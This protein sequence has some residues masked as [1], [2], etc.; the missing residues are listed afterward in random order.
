MMNIGLAISGNLT[1]FSRFY[2][3]DEAKKLL[4]TAKFNFDVHNLVSF[5]NNGEKLYAIFFSKD[6]VAVSLITNILDSFRRPGNLVVTILIPRGFKIV[7][8]L[9]LTRANAL[10]HL[11]NEINDKFYERN[12][13]NGMVNQNPA[14]LMQ[15]YYTEILSKFKLEPDN[16]Q[17]NINGL[18]DITAP[19]KRTGYVSAFENSIPSYLSSLFRKSYEGYHHIF[20]ASNAPQ[21]IDEPAEEIVTYRVKIENKDKI[22]PGEIKI[23][24][25]IPFITKSLGDNDIPS[26][27]FTY[28]Q[29]I[30]G[31]AVPYIT[32]VRT[33]GETIVLNYNFPKEEKTIYFKFY[34]GANEVPLHVIRPLIV[35]SNGS[36]YPLSTDSW[37]FRG[38]EIY[39]LK[40]IKSG[41]TEYTIEPNSSHLDLQ[42]L[43][44][45]ASH[46]VYVGKG[47]IWNFN[48]IDTRT[49]RP[50]TIHPVDIVLENRVTGEYR[51]FPRVTGAVTERMS[52]KESDWVMKITSDY[53]EPITSTPNG[54]GYSFKRKQQPLPH[55][56]G[57]SQRTDVQRGGTQTRTQGHSSS[58]QNLKLSGGANDTA[59]EQARIEAEKKK[60]YIQIGIYA[61]VAIICCIGGWWGYTKLNPSKPD[62][63]TPENPIIAEDTSVKKIVKFVILDKTNDNL[64]SNLLNQVS[65][66]FEPSDNIL[67]TEDKFTRQFVYTSDPSENQSIRVCID[68]EK[69]SISEPLEFVIKDMQDNETINL[70]IKASDISEYLNLPSKITPAKKNELRLRIAQIGNQTFKKKF[71]DKLNRAIVEE[72]YEAPTPVVNNRIDWS[73]LDKISVTSSDIAGL[74]KKAHDLNITI[75]KKTQDR[76]NA[77]KGMINALKIGGRP[78]RNGLSKEQQ[79]EIDELFKADNLELIKKFADKGH[80]KKV[81]GLVSFR[82]KLGL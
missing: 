68:F 43:R 9:S 46:N 69:I 8:G 21:N 81:D 41:N 18:I 2:A 75:P 19:N 42:R 61:V 11:L 4:N 60:R 13:L 26:Q 78:S 72:S 53:Y 51:D 66:S 31:E 77:L 70:D 48:P 5:L 58:N 6:V 76:I 74:E 54:G 20:L 52:G 7:D 57:V 30:S 49:R 67:E 55:Q 80:F 37:T 62:D 32:G 25:K 10:Y 65:L 82:Q 47:W 44:D 24:D 27:D 34:D 22:V 56:G 15:D 71:E 39:G 33:D 3:N 63:P 28:E 16:S 59:K 1:G 38:K 73:V 12:F 36:S 17:R 64:S 35:E 50:V 29:V 79:H 14:V 40:T 45:G 23:T